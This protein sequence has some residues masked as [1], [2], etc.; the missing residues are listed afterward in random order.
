[1][2]ICSKCYNQAG[3]DM[4]FCPKC[5]SQLQEHT[6]PQSIG[7]INASKK[8]NPGCLKILLWIFFLPVMII[9]AISKSTKLSKVAKAI[10]ISLLVIA[11]IAIVASMPNEDTT[12]AL[13]K[14]ESAVSQKSKPSAVSTSKEP[15][16]DKNIKTIMDGTTLTQKESETVFNDLKSVGFKSISSIKPGAGKGVDELQSYIFN[17]DSASATVTIEKRKTYYIGSGSIDLYDSTKG[18]ILDQI[19]DYIIPSDR[20][21]SALIAAENYVEKGLKAPSTA[22][23]P[24][25]ILERDEWTV[26]RTKDLLQVK[27]YVD[28]ENGFGAMIR[29]EFVVQMDYETETLIYMSIADEVVYGTPYKEKK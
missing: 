27:S 15:E 24:G 18:G 12:T 23:F 8:N 10:L 4:S 7:T 2:K 14:T 20:E 3:D 5:G 9:I 11:C 17:C 28:S 21:I 25:K 16:V 26:G 13:N 6:A 22:K 1:M 29:S 19:T